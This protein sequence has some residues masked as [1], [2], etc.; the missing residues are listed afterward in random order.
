MRQIDGEVA[1]LGA[2]AKH[3]L[4]MECLYVAL[5]QL[6]DTMPY[7]R[8]TI[9]DLCA[10]AGVSRMAYYRN[11]NDKSEILIKHLE[12]LIET[13]VSKLERDDGANER[14]IIASFFSYL[15]AS[16][17]GKA[18]MRAG[19]MDQFMRIHLDYARRVYQNVLHLELGDPQSEMHLYKLMG[20]MA[21]LMLYLIDND[22][23][24]DP[25]ELADM[26]LS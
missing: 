19:L 16:K 24:V 18:I 9:T 1:N 12:W 25:Y 26:L 22:C 4:A 20:G 2:A 7:E 23:E 8:I 5:L 21:G 6:M 15:Q 14:E 17:V 10:R 11:F 13:S 3:D